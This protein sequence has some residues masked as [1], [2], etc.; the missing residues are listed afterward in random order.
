VIEVLGWALLITTSWVVL[1]SLATTVI[2]R[3]IRH[4]DEN[5]LDAVDHEIGRELQRAAS[6]TSLYTAGENR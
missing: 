6:S 5:E 4:A 2:G 3:S 1:A